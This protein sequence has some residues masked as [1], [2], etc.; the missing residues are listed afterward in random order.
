MNFSYSFRR[1]VSPAIAK[2]RR[3][4]GSTLALLLYRGAELW[5]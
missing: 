3:L 1:A 2:P 5:G 4:I